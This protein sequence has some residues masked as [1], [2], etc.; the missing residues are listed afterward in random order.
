MVY[1]RKN[2]PKQLAIVDEA[3]CTGCSACIEVCPVDCI[4]LKESDIFPQNVVEIDLD[5]CI[6]CELCVHIKG[7]KSNPY[8]LK[9]CPWDAIEMIDTPPLIER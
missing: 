8:D 2:L 7:K 4:F 6:G 1:K 9:V 5:T 3:N